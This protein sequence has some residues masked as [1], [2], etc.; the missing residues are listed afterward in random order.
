MALDLTKVTAACGAEVHGLDLSQR[1]DQATIDALSAALGERSVLFF[2][3]QKLTPPQHKALGECFG[4]LHLH[5][6]WPKLVPGHPEIMEIYTD[7]NSTHIAGEYWH[8]DVSCDPQPPMG[9]ILYM[10]EVPPVGGEPHYRGRYDRNDPEPKIYPQ[11][12]HPVIRTHPVT[13]RNAIFVNRTFTTRIVQLTARE[14]DALLDMLFHHLEQPQFQCRFKWEKG[15]VA[16]WDNRC[17]LHNAMWDYFPHR[18]RGH[19]VTIKGETPYYQSADEVTN[20]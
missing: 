16:V 18:R 4:E 12:E 15:S 2:R 7:E 20:P 10:I 3:N 5:P 19:R 14:S 1:L 8:S 9:T 11:A 13:G 17:A 6:A